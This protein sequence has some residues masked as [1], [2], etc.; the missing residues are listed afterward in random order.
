MLCICV[1]IFRHVSLLKPHIPLQRIDSK[2]A[3]V[4]QGRWCAVRIR[5]AAMDERETGML[6]PPRQP[7][8]LQIGSPEMPIFISNSFALAYEE[9]RGVALPETPSAP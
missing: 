2:I 3:S 7:I 4:F 9:V 8:H 5:A 1:T 6:S